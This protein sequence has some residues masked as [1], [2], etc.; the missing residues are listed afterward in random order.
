MWNAILCKIDMI[1]I[2]QFNSRQS[3]VPQKIWPGE[4]V[5]VVVS[6]LSS[7]PRNL[8]P[9]IKSLAAV[10]SKVENGNEWVLDL[11]FCNK[12]TALLLKE[13]ETNSSNYVLS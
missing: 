3:N 13:T 4:Q 11:L 7:D 5:G 1:L 8:S 2:Q 12:K 6:M 9:G 10:V